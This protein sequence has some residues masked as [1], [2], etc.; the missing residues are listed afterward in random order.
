MQILV[1]L[2]FSHTNSSSTGKFKVAA[3]ITSNFNSNSNSNSI[4]F[5][6]DSIAEIQSTY[7][8]WKSNYYNLVNP[9]A[10]RRLALKG[11]N[12]EKKTNISESEIES[13]IA[14]YREECDKSVSTLRNLLNEWL[15][16]V[17][18]ELEKVWEL[19]P[20]SDIYF[21]V[22][23]QNIESETI[24]ETLHKIPWREW[25]FFPS[26][27]TLEAA[28]CLNEA[29]SKSG[30]ESDDREVFRRI[31][32]ISIFGDVENI[33]EGVD[34]DREEIEKLEQ[35][36]AEI[37][38]LL[39]PKRQEL[40][41]LWNEPC[42]ILFYSGHSNSEGNSTAGRFKIN[43]DDDLSLEE[44][45]NTFRAAIKK[46]LQIAIFNSCDGLGLACELAKINLPYVIVW[47]ESVPDKVAQKFIEFFLSSY[48]Q[49][50]SLFN[51]V[52]QARIQLKELILD[53]DENNQIPGLNWLPIICTST[54]NQPPTWQ[55]LGGLTG[56]LPDSPYKGLSAFT[57]ED[58]K[59]YFGREKFVEQLLEATRSKSFVPIVGAS[60]SGKSSVVYGGLVPRLREDGMQIVSF[61]PGNNPFDALAVA[62]KN[63]ISPV[64][65]DN[66]S[67]SRE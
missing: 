66:L 44:I 24:A 58:A 4:E 6:L 56:K 61:R 65:E 9:Q 62:L 63:Q 55:N 38:P 49:G 23:T 33:Q 34:R 21:V 36:G 7:D 15:S 39:Q 31:R 37:I 67:L 54:I 20:S 53:E 5:E 17:K 19:E 12:T 10:E 42:D 59:Y 11:F 8:W 45:R 16:P 51:A 32:I 64:Q 14:Y 48:S 1:N 50:E 28:L 60:G 40:K 29:D 2:K 26:C 22:D 25:D 47:R 41:K 57:E 13:N 35:R 27:Y 18:Y 30:T 52:K 46:G 3:N 43:Q